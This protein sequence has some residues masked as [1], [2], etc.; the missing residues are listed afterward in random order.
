M[1]EMAIVLP[2]LLVLLLAVGYFGHTVISMQ[3][4]HAGRARVHLQRIHT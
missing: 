3:N 2:L 1:I 4:L